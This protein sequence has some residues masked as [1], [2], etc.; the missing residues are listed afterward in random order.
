MSPF[1]FVHDHRDTYELKR[2]CQV[3]DV[4]RSSC[5]KWL[6]RADARAARQREDQALAERIRRIHADSGGTQGSLGVIAQLR[7]T[8]TRANHKRAARVMRTCSI[9]GIH[10][11]RRAR[12]TVPDPAATTVA[13][14]FQRDFTATEPGRK[15]MGAITYLPPAGGEFLYLATVLDRF[16]RK[17]VGWS[18]ADHMRT[19]LAAATQPMATSAPTNTNDATTPLNSRSPRDNQPR[20]HLHGRRPH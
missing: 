8:G 7:E 17:A 11:R 16:S 15:Y 5:D 6:G 2:L 18:I 4:N 1:Q 13:D 3:L 20:V 10:L 12:T 19:S 9:V 14:L